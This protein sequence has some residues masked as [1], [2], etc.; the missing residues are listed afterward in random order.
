M[1]N[2]SA[3]IA[4]TNVVTT[5]GTQTLTNK[6]LTGAIVNG[7]VGATTPNTG[8]FTTLTT[9]STVTHNGGTANG[10]TYL[11]GSKVLTSGSALTFDGTDVAFQSAIKLL[12]S[13]GGGNKAVLSTHVYG[14]SGATGTLTLSSTYGNANR[15]SVKVGVGSSSSTSFEADSVEVMRVTATGLK[16]KTSISVGDA[17]PTTNGAGITFPAT[18]SAS[19]NANTLDDYEEGTWTPGVNFGGG[20]TGITYQQQV[21]SYTKIGNRVMA[22]A[23]VTLLTKGS[24]SGTFQ[25]TGL[26]FTTS[27]QADYRTPGAIY[28]SQLTFNSGHVQVLTNTSDT[29]VFFAVQPDAGGNSNVLTEANCSNTTSPRIMIIYNVD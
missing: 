1:A 12:N 29:T 10:V 4:P 18:Q 8:A 23:L 17:T 2:L 24:S 16:T 21:G 22:Q 14:G 6:T 20:T 15:T 9:S 7:T 27:S 13:D 28:F 5:T 19:S 11:N 26:P 25:L 3:I